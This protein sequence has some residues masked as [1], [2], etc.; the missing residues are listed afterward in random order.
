MQ[1]LEGRGA[2]GPGREHQAQTVRAQEEGGHEE[3][4][5]RCNYLY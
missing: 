3:D 1:P 5:K 4:L 2:G